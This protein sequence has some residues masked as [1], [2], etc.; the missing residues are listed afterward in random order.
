[1]VSLHQKSYCHA[2]P[3][4]QF[5]TQSV[6]NSFHHLQTLPFFSTNHPYLEDSHHLFIPSQKKVS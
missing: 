3:L 6:L 4:L 5:M 1:L 2:A